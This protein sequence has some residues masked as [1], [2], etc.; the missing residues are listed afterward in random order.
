MTQVKDI[1]YRHIAKMMA[2]ALPVEGEEFGLKVEQYLATIKVLPQEAKVAL[3][4]AYIFSRKVP[5]EEREDLFQDIAL[6][7]LKIRTKDERLGYA[8]AR[9]DWRDFWKKYKIRQHYSLDSVVD[10]EEGNPVTLAELLVGETEFERKINGKLDAER[11][12]DSLPDHIQP[13]IEKRLMGYTLNKTERN[14]LNYFVRKDGYKII[15]NSN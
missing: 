8:I 14:A 12:F 10:D 5:R 2:S 9:C 4:S 6:A 15:L 3:K 11:I 1:T 7:V 13:L